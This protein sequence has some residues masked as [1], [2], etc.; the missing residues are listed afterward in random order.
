M[1]FREISYIL[2]SSFWTLSSKKR[3]PLSDRW[4]MSPSKRWSGLRGRLWG[5]DGGLC[6]D[7]LLRIPAATLTTS[8]C[9][10]AFEGSSA[11]K[12][13]LHC[14]FGIWMR[15]LSS[16]LCQSLRVGPW[17]L[18]IKLNSAKQ[19]FCTSTC[20][21]TSG[22]EE[23]KRTCYFSQYP[24]VSYFWAHRLFPSV[25]KEMKSAQDRQMAL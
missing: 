10:A 21:G 4:L 15:V 22:G 2:G 14:M 24:N 18:A 5:K 16:R 1:D 20:L 8:R 6:G 12:I 17:Q 25:T 7:A 19:G 3:P 23:P 9:R 13:L 11:E